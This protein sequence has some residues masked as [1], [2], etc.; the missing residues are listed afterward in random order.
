MESN[1]PTTVD[2]TNNIRND[3]APGHLAD[4]QQE[5]LS[6]IELRL[7]SR[8]KCLPFYQIFIVFLTSRDRQ[9]F[10]AV[11]RGVPR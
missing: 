1:L 6:D 9:T 7:K 8:F 10:L 5:E 11:P 3:I 4:E 2:S